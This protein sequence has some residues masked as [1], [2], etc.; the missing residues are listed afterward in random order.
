MNSTTKLSKI[1][2][3]I[4]TALDTKPYNKDKFEEAYN[5]IYQEDPSILN[6][7][8]FK[9]KRN[10]SNKGKINLLELTNLFVSDFEEETGKGD[11]FKLYQ[12]RR[13]N[14]L[15]ESKKRELNRNMS[16][17]NRL[18]RRLNGTSLRGNRTRR[19]K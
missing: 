5:L 3:S 9:V 12:I 13:I 16:S 6:K 17:L 10:N 14:D 11:S 1:L 4:L 19:N 2:T 7:S 8:I 18:T 15:L